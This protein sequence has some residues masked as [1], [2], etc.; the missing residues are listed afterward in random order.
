MT[1]I[2]EKRENSYINSLDLN[3]DLAWILKMHATDMQVEDIKNVIK[4]IL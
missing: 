4:W 2:Q 3:Q 1:N